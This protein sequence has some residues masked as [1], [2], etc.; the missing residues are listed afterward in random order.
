MAHVVCPWWLGYALASPLRRL[1]HQPLDIL[2]PLVAGGMTVLEPGC[3]M[4]FFTLDLARLVGPA[5]RVVAV[6]IQPRMLAG[7]GRRARRA[8]LAGRIDARLARPEGLGLED[9]DG[10][11]DFALA[12]AMVHEVPDAARFYAEL[13]RALGQGG[14]VLLAEPKGHVTERAFAKTLALARSAGLLDEP[15]PP[16]RSHWAALLRRA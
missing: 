9:L 12:F 1:W 16:I 14:T 6:D 10:R 15:A 4:G 11:V 3:G 7:L 13:H 8:G 2:R 5:G